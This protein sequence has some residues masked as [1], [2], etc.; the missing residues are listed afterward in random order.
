MDDTTMLIIGGGALAILLLYKTKQVG[1]EQISSGQILSAA[2]TTGFVTKNLVAI[3]GA[4]WTTPL[5]LTLDRNIPLGIYG[6]ET[7]FTVGSAIVRGV[8]YV[9]TVLGT[10]LSTANQTITQTIIPAIISAPGNLATYISTGG[11]WQTISTG[12][13]GTGVS[14]VAG[15]VMDL[16]ENIYNA[17]VALPGQ[18]VDIGKDVWDFAKVQGGKIWNNITGAWEDV[19]NLYEKSKLFA[20]AVNAIGTATG[21]IIINKLTNKSDNTTNQQKALSSGIGGSTS[22]QLIPLG[23]LSKTNFDNPKALIVRKMYNPSV[24]DTRIVTDDNNFNTSIQ[25][26]YK[27]AGILG[28]CSP[29]PFY[30]CINMINMYNPKIIDSITIT[31]YDIIPKMEAMGYQSLGTIGYCKALA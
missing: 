2:A 26:G 23:Y 15:E 31:N 7:L 25:L 30:G 27:D 28:Y 6:L 14:W 12:P 8:E 18:I 20:T 10:A 3:P 17:I 4:D 29:Q 11:L 19:S 9:G 1:A 21:G 13:L 16:P 22:P 24:L 5:F